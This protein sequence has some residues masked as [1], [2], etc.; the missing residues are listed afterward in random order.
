MVAPSNINVTL[1]PELEKFVRDK[2][3]SG[4]YQS[5]SE[6]LLEGLM[7]LEQQER[8]SEQ[9]FLSLK[10]KLRI[11]AEEA[12]HGPLFSPEQVRQ[13]LAEIKRTRFAS[14]PCLMAGAI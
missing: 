9:D 1:T 5:E 11:A 10:E 8:E 3:A 2:F 7:L 14:S 4:Q 6:V 12:E 13:E